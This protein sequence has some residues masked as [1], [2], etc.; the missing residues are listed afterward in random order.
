MH[1][2]GKGVEKM[3]GI[4][5]VV[6]HIRGE[7]QQGGNP[8]L[9]FQGELVLRDHVS[10]TDETPGEFR[11]VPFVAT[12][13]ISST[14]VQGPRGIGHRLYA[15]HDRTIVRLGDPHVAIE[16][17]YGLTAS[18]WFDRY[19]IQPAQTE[20]QKRLLE[21]IAW[22]TTNVFEA[23]YWRNN[24]QRMGLGLLPEQIRTIELHPSYLFVRDEVVAH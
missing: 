3:L 10:P 16:R 23:R 20:P 2:S 15:R 9:Q 17:Q 13:M 19:G 14:T 5:S 21:H 4:C 6:S 18:G 8:F 22:V 7:W 12:C 11:V 24:E 1:I